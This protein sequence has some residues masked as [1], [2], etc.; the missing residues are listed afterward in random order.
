MTLE[1]LFAY[2]G[3]PAPYHF[4]GRPLRRTNNVPKANTC[5]YPTLQLLLIA[6][7]LESEPIIMACTR[8]A[9]ECLI[10]NSE[11]LGMVSLYENDASL[12]SADVTH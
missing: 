8:K 10:W 5:I 9:Q 2:G 11:K 6:N 3:L 12:V 1:Q 4:R 7:Y